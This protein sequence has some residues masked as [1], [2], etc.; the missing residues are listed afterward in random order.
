[1]QT[2]S[3][4]FPDRRAR[5]VAACLAV[6]ALSFTTAGCPGNGVRNPKKSNTRLDLAKDFLR[7]GQL[8]A[9]E[10]E[11][12]KALAFDARNVDAHNVLGLVDF[13]RAL[14]NFKDREVDQCLTGVDRDAA[15]PD[16]DQFL[17][18][19][20]Q[21]FE[22]TVEINPEFGEGWANRGAVA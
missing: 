18:N 15:L 10:Q 9:A 4:R 12:Q 3:P 16:F 1:M 14:N 6:A 19:A 5:A 8:E 17:K 22:K 21:H 11:G 20:D 7:K 2:R 13:V